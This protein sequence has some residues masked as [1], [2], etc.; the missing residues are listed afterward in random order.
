LGGVCLQ[1]FYPENAVHIYRGRLRL[2][3][4]LDRE[5][6][7][8][9]TVKPRGNREMPAVLQFFTVQPACWHTIPANVQPFCYKNLQTVKMTKNS[10][11]IAVISGRTPRFTEKNC[12]FA[13]F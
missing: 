6:T 5:M 13:G 12:S 7:L 4:R 10:C 11:I 2:H 9:E 3:R 1:P 8:D